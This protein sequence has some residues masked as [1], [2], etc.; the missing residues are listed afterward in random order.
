MSVDADGVRFEDKAKTFQF[1]PW[2]AYKT[3]REGSLIFLLRGPQRLSNVVPKRGLT[4]EQIDQLR[5]QLAMHM[6]DSA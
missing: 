6:P 4:P 2:S 1:R 3:W 5:V